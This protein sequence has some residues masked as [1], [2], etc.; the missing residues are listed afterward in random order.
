MKSEKRVTFFD[1]K[2]LVESEKDHLLVPGVNTQSAR[3]KRRGVIASLLLGMGTLAVK[4]SSWFSS[5]EGQGQG[6]QVIAQWQVPTGGEG[7]IIAIDPDSSPKKLR[8]LG[9][10]LREKFRRVENVAVM[11]FDDA[12]AAREVRRGSR[13]VTEAKFQAALV[14]QRA[15]Y[16]KSTP[17][18]E[19]RFIIYRA[20]PAVA[21]VIRLNES[22]LRKTTD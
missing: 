1:Q 4:L 9:K 11:I 16:L 13:T 22:D 2:K 15:M 21:E 12:N 5:S 6:Y 14:H 18:D 17:R 20:Y 7:L 10:R 19:D 8:E 3:W